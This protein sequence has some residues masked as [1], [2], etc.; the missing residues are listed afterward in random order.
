MPTFYRKQ[1]NGGL[2]TWR[3]WREMNAI[4][5]AHATIE[6]G[7]E[8]FHT[9]HVITNQSGRSIDEQIALRIKSRI[10]RALDKGY[11][12][13][14]EEALNS[15]SN[16]LGLLRPMLAKQF[17]KVTKIDYIDAVL[18]K[19]LDGHRCM[20]TKQDGVITAYSRQGKIIDTIP[21]ITDYL[22]IRIPE[23][24]TIDGELYLHG[25]KLQTLASW[26]KR[27]QKDTERLMFVAYD[28]VSPDTYLDRYSELLDMVTNNNSHVKV[29]GIKPYETDDKMWEYFHQVRGEG[30]EGLMLRT[31]TK[32]YE[33]GPRSS[34]LIKIKAFEDDEF[35]VVNL[36]ASKEG[37]A[38][39]QCET[40]DGQIFGVSAPGNKEE[41]QYVMRNPAK[42]IGRYLTVDYSHLTNDLIPFHPTAIRW[43]EDV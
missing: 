31:R 18:Q 15:S 39:C 26:I 2:G 40:K 5:I 19:K 11:K 33:A 37:W 28:L 12:P 42:F 30:F 25:F 41:K 3:I 23:G 14:R 13:T 20:V 8:V 21:H 29:L 16:Q 9:E 4:R 7:A 34:S 36:K 32:G 27:K 38:I 1:A 43:R 10:S 35:L 22:N 17:D 6:G 24:T